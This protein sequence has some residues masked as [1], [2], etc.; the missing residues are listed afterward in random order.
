MTTKAISIAPTKEGWKQIRTVLT[1]SVTRVRQEL[2]DMEAYQEGTIELVA[3][4]DYDD[5]VTDAFSLLIVEKQKALQE[6][7]ISIEKIDQY[8]KS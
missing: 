1:D 7:L 6:M 8:L 2:G 3:I 5:L 4:E